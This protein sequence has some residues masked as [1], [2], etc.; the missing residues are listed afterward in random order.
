MPLYQKTIFHQNGC[1]NQCSSIS[2][3]AI[4]EFYCNVCGLI[5][6]LDGFC[7]VSVAHLAGIESSKTKAAVAVL[8]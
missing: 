7:L 8:L 4:S 5:F 1:Y 6:P 3:A 2:D